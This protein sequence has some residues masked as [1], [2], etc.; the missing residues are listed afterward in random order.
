M[1][2]DVSQY[3]LGVPLKRKS[4]TA[5][6]VIYHM[7]RVER[8]TGNKVIAVYADK[9]K[10]FIQGEL[11]DYCET[12]G[13][14]IIPSTEY[15]PEQNSKPEIGNK[16]RTTIAECIRADGRM[17]KQF[18]PEASCHAR[19]LMA[20]SLLPNHD[21]TAYT[22]L[23]GRIFDYSMLKVWACHAFAHVPKKLRKKLDSKTRKALYFGVSESGRSYKLYDP[24]KKEIFYSATVIFDETKTGIESLMKRGLQHDPWN[25]ILSEDDDISLEEEVYEE[26]PS[27]ETDS[28]DD[29]DEI[30]TQLTRTT[31]PRRS[32]RRNKGVNS[33][34]K[35]FIY[36]ASESYIKN[37]ERA[38]QAL[39]IEESMTSQYK[40]PKSFKQATSGEHADLWWESMK[41]EHDAHNAN[42]TWKLVP[43]PSNTH[44]MRGVWTYRIKH[45]R[46]RITNFKSRFCADG[47]RLECTKEEVHAPMMR[48]DSFRLLI[49][50]AT[51]NN[52]K[53]KS[54]D[55]PAAYLKAKIPDGTNMFVEQPKGFV[56]KDHPDYVCQLQQAIYGAPPSGHIWNDVCDKTLQE[57]GLKRSE[58]DPAL[59]YKFYDGGNFLYIGL[60]TDDFA[61]FAS[62]DEI[63]EEFTEYMS[64]KYQMKGGDEMKWFLG[65]RVDQ[66]TRGVMLSQ[67]EYLKEILEEVKDVKLYNEMTPYPHNIRDDI[68]DIEPKVKI[69]KMLGKL[70]Y[71]TYTRPDIEYA[72]NNI[73]RMDRNL[74]TQIIN[75]ILALL[76]YL[77]RNTSKGLEFEC[78]HVL[79]TLSAFSDSSF[80]TASY[81]R[82][83]Y[84]YVIMWCNTPISW[85]AKI[86]N[87]VAKSTMEAEF[88]AASECVSE[89]VF[90]INL[91]KE[92]QVPL[93]QTPTLLVDSKT[94]KILLETRSCTD[95]SKHIQVRYFFVRQY[96]RDKVLR[97]NYVPSGENVA[98]IFTKQLL[99]V[100]FQRHAANLVKDIINSLMSTKEEKEEEANVIYDDVD[101]IDEWED[102][103]VRELIQLEANE[104]FD[105]TYYGDMDEEIW[106]EANSG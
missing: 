78:K 68:E 93:A 37:E 4:D 74:K 29:N 62:N 102:A 90:I 53:I 54:G 89:L 5:R 104:Q 7:K 44:V 23:K 36:N 28:N 81:R 97:V 87:L 20:T 84:G 73:C 26:I 25:G 77:Q 101:Y 30:T 83:P 9:A 33:D 105:A 31:E 100:L 40:T 11:A 86:P 14:E 45:E 38:L 15:T 96:I 79:P 63:E 85:R 17:S 16:R 72:L 3:D 13:I 19:L 21:T 43:R 22:E 61:Y 2:E 52:R 12:K 82:S 51:I 94:A 41:R 67:E 46:G 69:D 6:H 80:A 92:L 35:D 34:E 66:T 57:F 56:D 55:I 64:R 48:P 32:Q 58:I 71:L 65:M 42:G 99:R 91:I 8:L 75:A 70:R 95:G 1:I 50:I 76:G 98:D 103:A 88:I 24:V 27:L 49:G 60:A 10:E 47:S 18:W 39:A 106:R 59:Y